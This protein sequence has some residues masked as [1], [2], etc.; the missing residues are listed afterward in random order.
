MRKS[1]SFS[2]VPRFTKGRNRTS[3]SLNRPSLTRARASATLPASDWLAVAGDEG[4]SSA[5]QAGSAEEQKGSGCEGVEE[6]TDGHSHKSYRELH[7]KTTR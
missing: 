6:R 1:T 2:I 7:W 4:T 3:A 5:L